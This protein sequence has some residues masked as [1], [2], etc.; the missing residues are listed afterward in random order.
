MKF[1]DA[2]HWLVLINIPSKFFLNWIV[3]KMNPAYCWCICNKYFEPEDFYWCFFIYKWYWLIDWLLSVYAVRTI[4]YSF[5][6]G[7]IWGFRQIPVTISNFNIKKP[8]FFKI[9]FEFWNL[10]RYS[11]TIPK[12]WT[13]RIKKKSTFHALYEVTKSRRTKYHNA[14]NF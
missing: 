1:R 5:N 12:S 14:F 9:G 7:E 3:W 8:Y 13:N 6:G 10:E 11:Q 4:F 2:Y